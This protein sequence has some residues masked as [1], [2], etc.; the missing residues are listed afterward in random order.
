[1]I[2]KDPLDT[3]LFTA[4]FLVI[5]LMVNAQNHYNLE[6]NNS[7][8]VKVKAEFEDASKELFMFVGSSSNL[9]RGQ[10]EFIKN[11][12]VSFEGEPAEVL[13]AENGRWILSP[14]KTNSKTGRLKL[15]Y[16]I[17]LDF[18]KYTW[19]S[20]KEEMAF[21]FGDEWVFAMR[22]LLIWP[23]DKYDKEESV[24]LTFTLPSE[25]K[26]ITLGIFML[27]APIKLLSQVLKLYTQIRL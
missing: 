8:I 14:L 25:T 6:F 26:V 24:E 4:F 18:D 10:V 20:G 17:T 11:L 22:S 1:M 7:G 21:S 13:H 2:T 15:E 27:Q 12:K 5:T 9:E 3:K 16:D 19:N 23:L